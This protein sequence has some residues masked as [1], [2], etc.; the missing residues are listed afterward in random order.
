VPAPL[1][2]RSGVTD[3]VVG[4]AQVDGLGPEAGAHG[5]QRSAGAVGH[6]TEG[7][8]GGD[9]VVVLRGQRRTPADAADG[10][11]GNDVHHRCALRVAAQHDLGLRAL[12]YA[13]LDAV[14]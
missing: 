4:V 13:L 9:V 11:P 5:R 7:R 8:D 6:V 14:D 12:F 3:R 2:A 1:V 10:N